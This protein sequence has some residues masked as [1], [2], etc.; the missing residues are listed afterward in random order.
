MVTIQLADGR[1]CFAVLLKEY[2]VSII[3][4]SLIK[5]GQC[6]QRLGSIEREFI[7]SADQCFVGPLQKFL[8]GEMRTINKERSILE[9]KRCDSIFRFFP[10]NIDLIF[11]YLRFFRLDLDAC[12]NRVRKARNMLGTPA[13]VSLNGVLFGRFT[14]ILFI[15]QMFL[16]KISCIRY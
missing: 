16:V 5:V 10:E 13:N 11:N 14:L 6:E 12:K 8:E 3:G 1:N 7:T 9:T 4:S 2:N 15:F